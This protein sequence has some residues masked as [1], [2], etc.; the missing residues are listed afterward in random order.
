M[1]SAAKNIF[2]VLVLLAIPLTLAGICLVVMT[3]LAVMI[4]GA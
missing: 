3:A 4:G 1:I 2:G